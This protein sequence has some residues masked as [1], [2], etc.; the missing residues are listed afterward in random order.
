[1]MSGERNEEDMDEPVI[2]HI[3]IAVRDLDQALALFTHLLG[4]SASRRETV[5]G[6][7]VDMAVFETGG[8]RIELLSPLDPDSPVGRFLNRRGPGIHHVAIRRGDIHRLHEHLTSKGF[9]APG[10]V[11]RGGEGRDVFFLKPGDTSGVLFE[12]TSPPSE[13]PDRD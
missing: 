2:D 13:T 10:G 8:T 11:R 7:G 3:G 5:E 4:V 1:L 12:F 6:E 9:T